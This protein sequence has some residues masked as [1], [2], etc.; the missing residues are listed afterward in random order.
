[1]GSSHHAARGCIFLLMS[2]H[3]ES[4]FEWHQDEVKAV[5]YL[6]P[7]FSSL[8]AHFGVQEIDYK[9]WLLIIVATQSKAFTNVSQHTGCA[10]GDWDDFI[11][12][13]AALLCCLLQH[14]PDGGIPHRSLGWSSDLR[15]TDDLQFFCY[16]TAVPWYFWVPRG[17]IVFLLFPY[18]LT[19]CPMTSLRSSWEC[20]P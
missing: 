5:I 3:R 13:T 15:V 18:R 4:A 20:W 10:W 1:M 8:D 9:F 19:W 2:E 17:F 12:S 11:N 14:C 6:S 7:V 16:L